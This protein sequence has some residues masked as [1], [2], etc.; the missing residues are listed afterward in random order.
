MMSLGWKALFLGLFATLF[1]LFVVSLFCLDVGFLVKRSFFTL[2]DCSPCVK[3]SMDSVVVGASVAVVST[4][5]LGMS[6]A[7][8]T[9]DAGRLAFLPSRFSSANS[10]THEV[11][12]WYAS[13]EWSFLFSCQGLF[14]AVSGRTADRSQGGRF[15]RCNGGRYECQE[16][17]ESTLL[18]SLFVTDTTHGPFS[19]SSTF[20]RHDVFDTMKGTRFRHVHLGFFRLSHRRWPR[21]R[22]PAAAASGSGLWGNPEKKPLGCDALVFQS[23]FFSTI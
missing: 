15:S 2:S 20:G 10:S 3:G 7:N 5:R 19:T 9:R 13:R 4:F 12:Q 6:I 18:T 17:K 8:V 22:A 21:A 16:R 11:G 14:D 23:L 1:R